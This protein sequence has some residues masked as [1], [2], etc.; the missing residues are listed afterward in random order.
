[1]ELISTPN[2]DIV[3]KNVEIEKN[4][5]EKNSNEYFGMLFFLHF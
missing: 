1:M 5:E 4:L 2:A 3:G